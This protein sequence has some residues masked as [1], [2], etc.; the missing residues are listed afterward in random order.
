[1]KIKPIPHLSFLLTATLAL[2]TSIHTPKVNAQ[3]ATIDFDFLKCT[4]NCRQLP[5]DNKYRNAKITQ[6]LIKQLP[7]WGN[8]CQGLTGR[9]GCY[10]GKT[11]KFKDGVISLKI[12]GTEGFYTD[13]KFNSGISSQQAFDI[14]KQSLNNNQKFEKTEKIKNGIVLHS[15]PF[16]NGMDEPVYITSTYLIFNSRNQVVRIVSTEGSP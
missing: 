2:S 6:Q 14:A 16:D 11:Y 3:P 15:N 1:M 10:V 5:T 12:Q 7:K 13:I 9:T 4:E 8:I